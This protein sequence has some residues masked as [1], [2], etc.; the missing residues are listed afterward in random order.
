MRIFDAAAY[1]DDQAAVATYLQTGFVFAVFNSIL[2]QL[3]VR[4]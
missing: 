2:P 1:L 4:P 3:T